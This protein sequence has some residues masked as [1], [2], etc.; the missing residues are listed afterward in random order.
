VDHD[1][2]SVASPEFPEHPR[3]DGPAALGSGLP[4]FEPFGN[5]EIGSLGEPLDGCFLLWEGDTSISLACGG[6]PNVSE[7]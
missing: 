6:N 2:A 4:F 5:R 3:P 1:A 7:I